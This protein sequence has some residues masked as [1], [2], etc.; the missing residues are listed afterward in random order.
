MTH[1]ITFGTKPRYDRAL[2]RIEREARSSGYFDTVTVYTQ[3]NLPQLR[4]HAD[5]V[6]KN[7]RGYGYW[8]WKPMA[9]LEQMRKVPEGDIIL[10]A[11]AGCSICTTHE[12]RRVWNI[13]LDIVRT[14]STHRIAFIEGHIEETWCKADLACLLGCND[15]PTI[16]KSC[17]SISTLHLLQNTEDNRA[18]VQRWIDVCLLEDYHYLTD[19][20]S[21]VPNASSFREHRH[22]QSIISLLMKIHG[23][24]RIPAPFIAPGYPVLCLRSRDA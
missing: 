21:R 18:L 11:D 16:M 13:W 12:A 1:F 8:I 10:Y 19:S 9:I 24:S 5:F 22:D 3:E 23:A 14:G 15:D 2:E 20:P 4:E 17:I 7:P 6:A